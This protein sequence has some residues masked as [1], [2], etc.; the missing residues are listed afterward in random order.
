[1]ID[2]GNGEQ[3]QFVYKVITDQLAFLLQDDML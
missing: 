1:M 2:E 3:I